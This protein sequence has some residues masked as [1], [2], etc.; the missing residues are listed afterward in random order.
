MEIFCS[1]C[2][3]ELNEEMNYCPNCGEPLTLL[4]KKREMLKH[5][6]AGLEMIEELT[7]YTKNP[8]LLKIIKDF[9]DKK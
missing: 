9:V 8:E 6:N 3:A 7:V 2:D 5:D 4:A 1:K